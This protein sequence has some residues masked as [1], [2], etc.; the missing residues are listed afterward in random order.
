[1]D[2][3]QTTERYRKREMRS[4]IS[5]LVRLVVLGL[6]IWA[7]WF[8]GIVRARLSSQAIQNVC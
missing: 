3:F 6:A 5:W 8:W 1:M 4:Q 2:Y 7:G